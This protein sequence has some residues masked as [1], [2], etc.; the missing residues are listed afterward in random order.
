MPVGR[1]K[2]RNG[3][4]IDF[5]F[6]HRHMLGKARSMQDLP[7]WQAFPMPQPELERDRQGFA[8]YFDNHDGTHCRRPG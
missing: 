1:S 6:M 7:S 5:F 4:G 2:D 3:S 8:R